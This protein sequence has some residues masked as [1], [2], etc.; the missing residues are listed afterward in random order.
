MGFV[1][2]TLEQPRRVRQLR[3]R[4]REPGLHDHLAQVFDRDALESHQHR[5]ICEEPL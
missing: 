5:G 4:A 2:N 3:R 1:T